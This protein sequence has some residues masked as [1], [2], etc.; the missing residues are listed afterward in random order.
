MLAVTANCVSTFSIEIRARRRSA[1]SLAVTR[2]VSGSR[3]ANSSPPSLPAMSSS[4][5]LALMAAPIR[6]STW[7]P[8]ACPAVSLICLK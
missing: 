4:R 3:M 5:R 6:C 7:S 2:G 1:I 8:A